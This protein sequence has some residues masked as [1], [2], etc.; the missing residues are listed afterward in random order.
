M[1][2]ELICY[3]KLLKLIVDFFENQKKKKKNQRLRRLSGKK[4]VRDG[5]PHYTS[6]IYVAVI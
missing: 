3:F 1:E 4:G 5:V 6:G 2:S